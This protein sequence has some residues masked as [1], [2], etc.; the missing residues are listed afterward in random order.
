MLYIKTSLVTLYLLKSAE[1]ILIIFERDIFSFTSLAPWLN[2]LSKI[3]FVVIR[4]KS[5]EEVALQILKTSE[6]MVE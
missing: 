5:R 6:L 1:C 4:K 2:I 3:D